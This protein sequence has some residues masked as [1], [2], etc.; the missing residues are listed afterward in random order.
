MIIDFKKAAGAPT[1]TIINRPIR[2]PAAVQV[3]DT[4]FEETAPKKS[5][6]A[7]DPLKD[8]NDILAVRDY[9][10]NECRYRDNLLFIMGINLGLRCGD[11]LKL[12][13][14]HLLEE[15]GTAYREKIVI[16]EQKTGKIREAYLNDAICDAADLYFSSCGVVDLND[17]LFKSNC[18]RVKSTG[19][20]MTVRSVERILKE[21]INDACGINIH[22]GTHTLRKTFSYHILM[23]APDRSRAIEFLMK[24]LGHSSPSVTLAY[25]GITSEEIK[26][27][28]QSLNLGQG[29]PF[30]GQIRGGMVS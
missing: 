7:A 18:N 9:L 5:K 17:Y 30:Q 2:R 26:E 4:T 12:K 10:V 19:S 3:A 21:V 11:L 23:N 14:G 8:L 20:P 27:S 24:I 15:G 16:T 6:E 29:S 13:V 22:A 25:A 28:Y 1:E